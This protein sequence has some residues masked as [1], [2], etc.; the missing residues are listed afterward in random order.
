MTGAPYATVLVPTHDHSLLIGYA[1]DSIRRQRFADFELLVVGDGAPPAT[2][3]VVESLA[4]SDPRIRYFDFPKGARHGEANRHAALAEARGRIVAY[5]GDDDLWFAD[6][7][8][9]IAWLLRRA[10][11]AHTTQ[12]DVDADG[13]LHAHHGAVADRR[14]RRRML[15]EG[16]G[17][18]GLSVAGHRLA[19]YRDLPEGWGP[20]PVG[21]PSDQ[22]MFRKFVARPGLRFA[23]GLDVTAI[24]I[25]T[26][27]RPGWSAAEREAELRAFHA[28]LDDPALRHAF[29]RAIARTRRHQLSRLARCGWQ[30][31]T[32]GQHWAMRFG[33]TP[34][35]QDARTR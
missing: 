10:D 2:R 6:H 1:L 18:F 28:R 24:H 33:G 21:Q 4:C 15:Q 7:L 8:A 29:R 3:E 5:C 19:A 22:T 11:F 20:A 26:P 12:V 23:T 35:R 32:F 31:A 30:L 17:F 27:L 16:Y 9:T 25:S 14:L 13:D 34:P